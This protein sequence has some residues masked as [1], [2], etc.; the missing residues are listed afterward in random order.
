MHV[1]SW[2]SVYVLLINMAIT[3]SKKST[4]QAGK[5]RFKRGQIRFQFSNMP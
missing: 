2:C 4:D 5:G 3:Y 1:Y